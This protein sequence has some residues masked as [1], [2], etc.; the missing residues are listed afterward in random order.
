MNKGI[1]LAAL[2]VIAALLAAVPALA[3][4]TRRSLFRSRPSARR[5]SSSP[6]PATS[7]SS[8]GDGGDAARLTTGVGIETDPSFSP[9]GTHV[10]FTGEYDGN[11]DVYVVPAVGR[12]A[13][14]AHLPPGAD[15]V[16]GWTPDGKRIL[17]RSARV[18]R[19]R[20]PELFTVSRRR[21]ARGAPLPTGDSGAYSPDGTRIAYVPTVQWQTRLEALPRRPTSPIWIADLADSRSRRS[22]AT[23]PTTSTR[24]G[25]ATG[26]LPLRPQR[27]MTLFAYDLATKKVAEALSRTRPRPQVRLGRARRAS[28]TSSSARSTSSTWRRRQSAA[29]P[30]RVER[31]SARGPP[32][33]REGRPAHRRRGPLP[34]GAR[35][36]FEARGEILTVP[37]EKG[38]IRN[39]TST[40]G[41]AERDPAWSP[42]GKS[43]AY[44][45][46]ESGEYAL[47]LRD[48]N[49]LG[50]GEEDRPR[51]AAVLLLPP[52]LVARQQEDRLHRQAPEPLVRRPRQGH[53][54]QG[55]RD[56]LFD[57]T[58]TFEPRWSPDSRWLAY[59]K[60]LPNHMTPVFVYSLETGKVTQ[61]TDGMSDA[62]YPAFDRSGKYLYFT[63]STDVG[64]TPGWLNMSS[65]DRP[66]TRSVYVVVLR[67][68]LPSPLAPESDEEKP[69]EGR[70]E[71]GGS[72]APEGRATPRRA[73]AT[74]RSRRRSTIDF[75]GIGQ[76]IL[77]LPV[78]AR[79]YVGLAAARKASSSCSKRL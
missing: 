79:N 3:L 4:P 63:A 22:R 24:C 36:V 10:A 27:P 26:L 75:D 68:D 70:A 56:P 25:S 39:L 1:K 61:V 69:K 41:V 71:E 43:I 13:A 21:R 7:G 15:A 38:D 32:A 2:I 74:P 33:L 48:Q 23:T 30:S 51:R 55:R 50:D 28:S 5:T 31:R 42:D 52:A 14:A 76:R 16:V 6:T 19:Q 34:D 46:D 29:V 66:V 18:R 65:I 17:F 8:A 12:R 72:K 78:P 53:P 57:P 20:L 47:H 77:A 59:A 11:L 37:A 60:Q 62:R 35:A 40:P 45:S 54:G 58:F 67:K 49:G 44:F 9:D 73:R 64:L